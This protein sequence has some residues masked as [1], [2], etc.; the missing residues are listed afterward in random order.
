[1][2]KILLDHRGEIYYHDRTWDTRDSISSSVGMTRGPKPKTNSC[3]SKR[4]NA[5]SFAPSEHLQ[6]KPP[7]RSGRKSWIEK[8][9]RLQ[10]KCM[11]GKQ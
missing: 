5:K 6:R 3:R 2:T 4:N 8:R 11:G 10:E 7:E 1:V 9:R